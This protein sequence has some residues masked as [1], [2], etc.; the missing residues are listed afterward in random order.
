MPF[1]KGKNECNAPQ[2]GTIDL[3]HR[4]AAS[5]VKDRRY[6]QR[7]VQAIDEGHAPGGRERIAR[8]SGV[9]RALQRADIVTHKRTRYRRIRCQVL[10]SVIGAGVNLQLRRHPC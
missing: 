4:R 10:E 3:A 9:Q 6:D 7:L 2:D 5:A 1:R 8:A